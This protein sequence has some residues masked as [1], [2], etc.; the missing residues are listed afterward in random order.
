MT[1][2]DEE[3]SETDRMNSINS[4]N[5]GKY[6]MIGEVEPEMTKNFGT[7]QWLLETIEKNQ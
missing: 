1:T 4:I 7:K 3:Y 2:K 6:C 5:L